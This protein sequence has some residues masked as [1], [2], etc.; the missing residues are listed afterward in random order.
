MTTNP[1]PIVIFYKSKTCG[2]CKVIESKWG[3]ETDTDN[4]TIMGAMKKAYPKIRTFVVSSNNNLGAFDENVVPS[5][6]HRWVSSANGGWFPMV[7]LVPGRVWNNATTTLGP[8]NPATIIDGVQIFNG[9]RKVD[10]KL[11]YVAKYN[12]RQPEDFGKWLTDA[13]NDE[14]F[15]KHQYATGPVTQAT[16]TTASGLT[17]PVLPDVGATSIKPLIKSTVNPPRSTAIISAPNQ[18]YIA[19]GPFGENGNAD[20]CSMHVIS[21]PK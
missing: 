9:T 1:E 7:L 8:K 17:V 2:H 13:L 19:A 6:L 5:D 18:T 3:K 21:R 11:I 16:I 15:K 20:I 4:S 10:G 12:P 14:E